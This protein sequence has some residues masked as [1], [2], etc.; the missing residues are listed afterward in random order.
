MV[1]VSGGETAVA[2]GWTVSVGTA[3]TSI[4][5]FGIIPGTVNGTGVLVG[6]DPPISVQ[7]A[8]KISK[9]PIK[10]TIGKRLNIYPDTADVSLNFYFS[11][12][13]Y[14]LP[15]V[16]FHLLLSFELLFPAFY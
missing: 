4:G 8:K 14:T 11:I 9:E 1:G 12:H 3:V 5:V 2:F 6:V 7:A 15:G 13:D 16:C 10:T